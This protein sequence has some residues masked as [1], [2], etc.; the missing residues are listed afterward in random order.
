MHSTFGLLSIYLINKK[1]KFNRSEFVSYL[2]NVVVIFSLMLSLIYLSD[3][4][5]TYSFMA[6]IGGAFILEIILIAVIMLLGLNRQEKNL[7][8][9]Y[10]NQRV[11]K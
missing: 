7:I 11:R 10:I 1:V 9:S 6:F 2:F 4:E 5:R 3:T 8:F